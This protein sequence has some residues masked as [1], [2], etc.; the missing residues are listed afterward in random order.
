[1]TQVAALFG[2]EFDFE[3]AEDVFDEISQTVAT[4]RGM[5]YQKLGS[6]GLQYLAGLDNAYDFA[7][8]EAGRDVLKR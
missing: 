6:E 1:L 8:K 2:A 3:K 4:F 5:A 7:M